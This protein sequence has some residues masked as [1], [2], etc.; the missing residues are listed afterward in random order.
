[1]SQLLEILKNVIHPEQGKDIV[2]LSMVENL[3]QEDGAIRFTLR[4]SKAHDPMAISIKRAAEAAIYQATGVTPTIIIAEPT[5]KKLTKK[6]AAHAEHAVK[7]IAVASGKGGVGKSTVTAN[8]AVSLAR[9]GYQVGVVDA[10]IYGPS[11]PKMFGTEDYVPMTETEDAQSIIPAQAHGVKIMS[12]GYFVK[13]SDALV[14]RG[15]MATNALKQLIHQTAW[16]K[17]D[18]LLIDL[19]PGTGD[20]HLTAVAELKIDGAIIVST[21][22]Q[23]ALADVVRGISM[24]KNENV[25]IPVL[26]LVNNMAYFTPAELPDNKYYIF[27]K[28]SIEKLAQ[29]TG[30]AILAEIPLVQSIAE[31]GDAGEPIATQDSVV[32][33]VFALLAQKVVLCNK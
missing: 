32:G 30:Y 18:Y 29:E 2:S 17:L 4:L 26:G 25:N 3:V 19:P 16:G 27:G 31:G 9:M 6:P 20:I 11:M 5:P 14:W 15:P 33:E 21:P 23:V 10:D 24:F 28:G 12:I 8:L 13:P 7:T 1:M 22:Q